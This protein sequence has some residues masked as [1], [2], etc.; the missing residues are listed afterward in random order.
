MG[1]RTALVGAL[2]AATTSDLGAP[3]SRVSSEAQERVGARPRRRPEEPLERAR[4]HPPR[5]VRELVQLLPFA[6]LPMPAIAE[7]EVGSC[8]A[9]GLSPELFVH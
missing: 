7:V 1:R 8:Q 2:V 3:S 6:P 4:L 5:Q 9:A